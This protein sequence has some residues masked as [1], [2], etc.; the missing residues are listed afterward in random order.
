MVCK[1]KYLMVIW[2]LVLN[3]I[4]PM[5]RP[6]AKRTLSNPL[7]ASPLGPR[8]CFRS[9]CHPSRIT[10]LD[11]I[12]R[13]VF[14]NSISSAKQYLLLFSWNFLFVFLQS[15]SHGCCRYRHA[16]H[17]LGWAD[18]AQA[19]Q[20]ACPQGGQQ[21]GPYHHAPDRQQGRRQHLVT[22]LFSTHLF[23]RLIETQRCYL[24]EAALYLRFPFV[25][26][27]LPVTP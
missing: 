7:A 16:L 19:R 22:I 5:A 6:R 4:D 10:L 13:A 14:C 1:I 23:A 27:L 24:V 21:R 15:C 25:S 11:C 26:Y 3:K 2:Y 12:P 9:F 18:P 17:R 20:W 8:P